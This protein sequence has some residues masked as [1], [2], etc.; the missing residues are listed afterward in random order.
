MIDN[1]FEE[2]IVDK[3]F[4]KMRFQGFITERVTR[5]SQSIGPPKFYKYIPNGNNQ[6]CLEYLKWY[7]YYKKLR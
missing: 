2:G 4:R 6:G 7:R 3:K 1:A 5:K